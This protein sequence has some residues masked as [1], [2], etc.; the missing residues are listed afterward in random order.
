MI[1]LRRL[2]AFALTLLVLA[3]GQDNTPAAFRTA[4]VRAK[5]VALRTDPLPLAGEVE[6]LSAGDKIE[7][8]KKSEKKFRSGNAEDFWYYARTSTGL[9][10][11]IY[12]A[13][14]SV[15]VAGDTE[16]KGPPLTETVVQENLVGKWWE[17]L[18]DG[19]TG[20]GRIYFWPAGKYKHSIGITELKE[21]SYEIRVADRVIEMKDGSPGGNELQI[22]FVGQEM[23][24]SGN[25][26]GKSTLFRRGDLDPE[27]REV[28][29]EKKDKER[30]AEERAGKPESKP[31]PK[32]E[33]KR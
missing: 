7:L 14:L 18:P 28:S 21:G 24:L 22:V 16:E 30:Q 2:A 15:A 27:A 29:D 4:T 6:I 31:E 1:D 11:W 32:A 17:L 25:E 20:A 26:D 10:G 9:E 3:C 12:G 33:P 8:L 23:R 13:G 19:S 5:K